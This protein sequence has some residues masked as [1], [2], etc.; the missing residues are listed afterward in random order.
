MN[1]EPYRW[2][3]LRGTVKIGAMYAAL[4]LCA[5]SCSLASTDSTARQDAATLNNVGTSLMSQQLLARAA[6]KFDQA[7]QRDPSL[8]L[9][10][11]N[12]GIALLYLQKLPEAK[13]ALEHSAQQNP[14]DP[15]TWY[16]LGLLYRSQNQTQEGV[17]AFQRVL[18]LDP[19]SA[20][21][22]YF[23]GS[24][25]LELHDFPAAV[26]EYRAAL[27]LNPLH[28]SAEFGLARALQRDGKQ[29]K[30]ALLSIGLDS[31]P[32]QSSPPRFRITMVKK[33]VW[34]PPKTLPE[35]R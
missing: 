22:H 23:L 19:S 32:A 24:F 12:K 11:T 29:T 7:Y 9:A 27:Q 3:Q 30:P 28:A 14:N 25:Q 18:A 20:D 13:A 6:E 5:S 10:E 33:A 16:V 17:K 1:V 21:S 4:L 2:N 35:E 26:T 15:H 31:S 8:A 34:P